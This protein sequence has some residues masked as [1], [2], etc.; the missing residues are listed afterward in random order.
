MNSVK[1]IRD[2]NVTYQNRTRELSQLVQQLRF[3]LVNR[4]PFSL[5]VYRSGY[6][7]LL[8]QQ[9]PRLIFIRTEKGWPRLEFFSRRMIW[10]VGHDLIK[11]L[12]TEILR[13]FQVLV[14]NDNKQKS[15]ISSS[16]AS[17]WAALFTSALAFPRGVL[18]RTYLT[19]SLYPVRVIGRAL[20]A[21]LQCERCNVHT[22]DIGIFISVN[23]V[24]VL[25]LLKL[26]LTVGFK[27]SNISLRLKRCG[28][29]HWVHYSTHRILFFCQNW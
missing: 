17:A 9:H 27:P 18:R 23:A 19:S 5:D 24:S 15:W 8:G 14:N 21:A 12:K 6:V 11:I 16:H 2:I 28:F 29:M 4:K 22:L 3:C 13:L 1:E 20:Q 26:L 7:T 10:V 25:P